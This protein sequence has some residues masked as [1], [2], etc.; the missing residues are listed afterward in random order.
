[1]STTQ[2]PKGVFNDDERL[3]K[4]TASDVRGD[5]SSE[6]LER[7]DT[8]GTV[9]TSAER[10]RMLRNEWSQEA[11][12]TPPQIPGYHLCWLSSTSSYDPIHK[13]L[14][15]GYTPVKADDVNG[16]ELYKMKSGEW[17]GHVSCNEMILFKIPNELYQEIMEEF[18]H[19]MP[20]EEEQRIRQSLQS[21]E[22]DTD[23]NGKRLSNIEGDGF[24][25]LAKNVR[26]SFA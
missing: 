5:R 22:G 21:M 24:N 18:H 1:M 16:F 9:S 4:D 3:R 12:P 10:R 6:D 13:R 17:E 26:P 20:L 11:L 8:D 23:S 14:R 19:N 2:K 25:S 15:M 7:T